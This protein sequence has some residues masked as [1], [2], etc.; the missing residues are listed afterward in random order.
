MDLSIKGDMQDV[1]SLPLENYQVR[2]LKDLEDTDYDNIYY[3]TQTIKS[4]DL[5]SS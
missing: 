1:T 2:Q 3:I 4:F 5:N